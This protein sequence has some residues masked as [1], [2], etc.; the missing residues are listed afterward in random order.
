MVVLPYYP[1]TNYW[2]GV[3][4][5]SSQDSDP[6]TISTF[7]SYKARPCLSWAFIS[8]GHSR[9]IHIGP[10]HLLFEIC[11]RPLVRRKA[12]SFWTQS[13]NPYCRSSAPKRQQSYT[14]TTRFPPCQ[15]KLEYRLT[16]YLTFVVSV[17]PVPAG[18]AGAPTNV[19]MQELGAADGK[20]LILHVEPRRRPR[21]NAF[22]RLASICLSSSL[23]TRNT[24]SKAIFPTTRLP[25]EF[26][27]VTVD[28]IK[29][30]LRCTQNNITS[31]YIYIYISIFSKNVL[32]V[33]TSGPLQ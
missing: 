16:G 23:L 10:K 24:P 26:A 3:S 13:A 6:K 19:I 25:F 17:F 9:E 32:V 15:P 20:S 31:I 12:F 1:I 28:H 4:S 22:C 11:A 30:D 14:A 18:P 21:S 29:Q 8:S 7:Y 27:T 2:L 33:F 5:S